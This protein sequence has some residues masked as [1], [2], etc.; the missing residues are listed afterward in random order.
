MEYWRVLNAAGKD[1]AP[2]VWNELTERQSFSKALREWV[3]E[4]LC[5]R[6]FPSVTEILQHYIQWHKQRSD[7]ETPDL[8]YAVDKLNQSIEGKNNPKP[9]AKKPYLDL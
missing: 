8:E 1:R 5:Y 6:D 9:S 4:R 7:E 2:L 3:E